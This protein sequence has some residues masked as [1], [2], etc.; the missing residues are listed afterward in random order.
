MS[1]CACSRAPHLQCFFKHWLAQPCAID[2]QWHFFLLEV[3]PVGTSDSLCATQLNQNCIVLFTANCNAQH[4][5]LACLC[6]LLQF[7]EWGQDSEPELYSGKES[8]QC[9]HYPRAEDPHTP[10]KVSKVVMNEA[11]FP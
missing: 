7:D 11:T 6:N 1:G 4:Q 5:Q 2:K 8:K 10:F 3:M 9:P